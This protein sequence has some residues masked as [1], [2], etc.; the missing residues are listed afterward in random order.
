MEVKYGK[1]LCLLYA[2]VTCLTVGDEVL[3]KKLC[4]PKLIAANDMTQCC[5]KDKIW[6]AE[7]GFL[8][9]SCFG[10]FFYF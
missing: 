2:F 9:E 1:R 6:A 8:A 3:P 4:K 10:R 5:A 7:E